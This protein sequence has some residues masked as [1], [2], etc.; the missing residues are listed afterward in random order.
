M[1]TQQIAGGSN[2]AV[3]VEVSEE[4]T[5][6]LL[7]IC[8]KL[9]DL[10]GSESG[11]FALENLRLITGLNIGDDVVKWRGQYEK[12]TSGKEKFKVEPLSDES[13]KE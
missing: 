3:V 13:E 5:A 6:L 4:D 9:V 11:R 1:R 12:W 2:I 7:D 8:G 10:I